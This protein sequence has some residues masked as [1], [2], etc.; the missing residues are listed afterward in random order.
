VSNARRSDRLRKNKPADHH[1]RER[2]ADLRGHH[3]ALRSD[4]GG[5]ADRLS[6]HVTGIAARRPQRRIISE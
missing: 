3:P 2:D 4:R 1:Q 5:R 6:E